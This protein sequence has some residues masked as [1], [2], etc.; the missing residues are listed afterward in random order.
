MHESLIERLR[1]IT[2]E[3]KKIL[4]ERRIRRDIYTTGDEFTIDR[5]KM[6][7]SGRLIDIRTHARFIAFPKHKHNYIEI[8]YMCTGETTHIINDGTKIVLKEGELLFFNQHCYHEILP[9]GENDIAV[10]F[11]MLPE[12]FD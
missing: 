6:L 5:K 10:N 8:T 2:D 3:E 1:P 7:G 11:M 4:E 9:A 12:F